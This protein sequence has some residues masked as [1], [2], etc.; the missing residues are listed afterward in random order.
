VLSPRTRRI[1]LTDKRDIYGAAGGRATVLRRSE[2]RTL[3]AFAWRHGRWTL[4]AALKD[5]DEVRLAPFNAVA[6][7]LSALWPD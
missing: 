4:L 6:F 7:P 3:E 2:A 5:V 1:D